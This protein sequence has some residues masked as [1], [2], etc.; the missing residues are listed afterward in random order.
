[1]SSVSRT[2]LLPPSQPRIYFAGISSHTRHQVLQMHIERVFVVFPLGQIEV[3]SQSVYGDAKR[4]E[5]PY[6]FDALQ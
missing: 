2:E 5:I 6:A 3:F 1:M 4:R